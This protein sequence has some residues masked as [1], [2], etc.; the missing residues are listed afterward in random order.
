[1]E[2]SVDIQGQKEIEQYMKK[3]S[4]P[5]KFFD[6]DFKAEGLQASR[7]L[8]EST[9]SRTDITA[10]SWTIFKKVKDSFYSSFNATKTADG[11]HLIA[12]ILNSGRGAV[13]PKKA[14]KLFIPLSENA[15]G[16]GKDLVFGEDFVYAD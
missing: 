2:F 9:P 6:G 16:G 14:K 4:N 13:R 8:K 11:K 12:N 1:M 15:R 7:R 5:E 3:L 10:G